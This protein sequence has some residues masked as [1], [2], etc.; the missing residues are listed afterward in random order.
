MPKQSDYERVNRLVVLPVNATWA[1][2][3]PDQMVEALVEDLA[4][5]D[6]EILKAAVIEVRRTCKTTPRI[7][8]LVEAC[9]KHGGSTRRGEGSDG[10]YAALKKRDED[11]RAMARRF[12]DQFQ[13]SPLAAR[14]R[15]EGWESPLLGYAYEAAWLQAQ[16]ITEARNPGYSHTVLTGHRNVER[17]ELD[18]RIREFIGFCKRQA[19]FGTIDLPEVPN[20][21]I[22]EWKREARAA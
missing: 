21:L 14:A 10:Y 3:L 6:D 16:Y 7:A 19:T 20:Y 9:Q 1:T 18:R 12:T 17:Q 2:K 8:H 22:D 4:G 13:L 5:Y 15:S 11:A